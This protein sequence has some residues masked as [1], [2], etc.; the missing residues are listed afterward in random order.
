MG[1][2][3]RIIEKIPFSHL[4]AGLVDKISERRAHNHLTLAWA[5]VKTAHPK[6]C[7]AVIP[8]PVGC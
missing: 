7:T 8:L 5:G 3:L 1:A 4:Q 6:E 2:L